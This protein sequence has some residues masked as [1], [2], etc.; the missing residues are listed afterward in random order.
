M[1]MKIDTGAAVSI[2]SRKTKQ[3]LFPAAIISK[4]LLKLSSVTLEPVPMLG[5]MAVQVKYGKYVG[6]N[7]LHD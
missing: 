5:Q 6:N 7:T 4:A 1:K 2:I 3:A